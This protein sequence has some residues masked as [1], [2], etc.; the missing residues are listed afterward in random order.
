MVPQLMFKPLNS[1]FGRELMSI[2]NKINPNY[3]ELE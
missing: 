3:G 2:L 1:L